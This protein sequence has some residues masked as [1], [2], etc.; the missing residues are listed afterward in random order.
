MNVSGPTVNNSGNPHRRIRQVFRTITLIL[1]L[2]IGYKAIVS[3]VVGTYVLKKASLF[4]IVYLKGT[5]KQYGFLVRP[6]FAKVLDDSRV[7]VAEYVII[8]TNQGVAHAGIFVNAAEVQKVDELKWPTR[9][10]LGGIAHV[11]R[12]RIT[13]NDCYIKVEDALGPPG[14]VDCLEYRLGNKVP[15]CG[16]TPT[17]LAH[18]FSPDQFGFAAWGVGLTLVEVVFDSEARTTVQED[19]LADKSSA[20]GITVLPGIGMREYTTSQRA[21]R[22]NVWI[23]PKDAFRVGPTVVPGRFGTIEE[24]MKELS[25]EA[26]KVDLPP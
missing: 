3:P 15:Q 24:I 1:A 21:F 18:A 8:S 17:I 16:A 12:V 19:S 11:A 5:L 20:E 10:I 26:E 22:L 13:I 9:P 4:D 2:V 6:L 23:G 14:N 25:E 7:F